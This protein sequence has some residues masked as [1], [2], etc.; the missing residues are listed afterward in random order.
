M[1]VSLETEN[2]G[3]I[4]YQ[5]AWER[6]SRLFNEV[7]AARA[8]H[9]SYINRLVFCEHPPVYTLGK[10]GKETN[11]LLGK[12]QLKRIGAELFHIDRGGDITFHGPGQLVCYP[13]LCLEDFHLGLK[14]YVS[15]LEEAV[16]G[17]CRSYGIE[18]GRVKGAT[19]VWLDIGTSSERKICAIGVRSS[20]FVTMHGLAL[21]VNT[22]LRY[23]GYIHPC[24]FIDKGVTSLAKETGMEIPMEEVCLRLEK[25]LRAHLVSF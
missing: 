23:F 22:D 6:Q 5:E 1:K 13:I 21:N 20:H 12:E 19:G 8:G 10:H 18:G 7:I 17:V 11:M 9:V 24:G 15:V 16:I 4:P 2:W 14:E 25:E 3:M